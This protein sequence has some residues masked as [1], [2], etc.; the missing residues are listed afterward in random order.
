MICHVVPVMI[1]FLIGSA[2]GLLSPAYADEV[3]LAQLSGARINADWFRYFNSRFGLAVDIPTKGYRYDVPDNGSGLT[4][5]SKLVTITLYAHFVS[6]LVPDATN[7]VQSSISQL[8]D[9]AIAQTLQK[10]GTVDY[11]VRKDDFY[12]ISG[13]FDKNVYYE[14]LTISAKCPGIFNSLRIFYPSSM[15]RRLD[16]LV[17]RMSRSLRATCQGDED[18]AKF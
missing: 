6:N 7:N 4:L 3:T 8:F 2:G 17:T 10:D 5:Q 13:M 12:V 16:G 11:S 18:S 1:L 14:R 9:D 15:E